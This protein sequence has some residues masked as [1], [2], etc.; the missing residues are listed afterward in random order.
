M[1]PY[2]CMIPSKVLVDGLELL[3]FG[4]EVYNIIGYITISWLCSTMLV[5]P[6]TIGSA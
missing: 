3:A 1:A 6:T 5:A 4:L 2:C